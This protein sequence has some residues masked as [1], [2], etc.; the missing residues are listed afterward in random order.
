MQDII[1]GL[2]VEQRGAV[3]T[4]DGPL[5]ILAG[6]GSGKTKTLTHRIAN[7]IANHG[8]RP[9]QILA[10]TFTNKAAKEMR[11]RLGALL[12]MPAESRNFMPYMGT[13]HGVCVRILKIEAESIGLT[14][15]FVIYDEDDRQSLIK[16]SIKDLGLTGDDRLKPKMISGI[17][18]KEK[19][20][21]STAKTYES[22]AQYPLQKD[23]A[24]VFKRYERERQ[25]AGAL[26]FDDLLLETAHLFK[27]NKEIREKWQKK[28]RHIL[29][30]EYQ[31]T[32]AVQYQIVKLLVND[33]Q[34]I[35]VVGD[36]WQSIYSWRGADF[37]NILNFE[38]DFPGAKVVK[39][40]QNYRSTKPILDAAHKVI[41][42]NINRTDK[43]L[44]TA[45]IE[46]DPVNVMALNDEV[47][48]S[49]RVASMVVSRTNL[50]MRKFNDH[51]VLYRTNAQ[52][53]A[54]ERAFLQNG[55]PYKIIGGLKFYD[56][57]EIKD[58]MAYL[59][60]IYQPSDIVSFNRIVNVP[61]RGIGEVSLRKFINA[62]QSSGLS[63]VDALRR[64]DEF[65]DVT[66]KTRRSLVELGNLLD[67]STKDLESGTLPS[68][69]IGG[70]IKRVG[71]E[72]YVDD[73][74]PQGDDRKENLGVLVTEASA[75]A[76]LEDFLADAA[77][78]SSAD[79]S[80]D[81]NVVTLMTLHAAKGL[82][83][84]VVFLVGMEEGLLPHVRAIDFENEEDIEEERRLAYVGMTRAREELNLSYAMCRYTYGQKQYSM[85]SR[86]LEGIGEK[87]APKFGSKTESEKRFDD[88][89]DVS[90][91]YM[92]FDIGDSVKSSQFGTGEVVDIDG[93][94]VS[95]KFG[96]GKLRKLNVE[97][98]RLEKS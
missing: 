21:F 24:K 65:S 14:R 32:N 84:P 45:N 73:G 72:E 92:P 7:L 54:F 19:N 48:E 96:D 87:Y 93:M 3:E 83:F 22:M 20:D 80:A 5:L 1:A 51:A 33:D 91:D 81:G 13:F 68:V 57:K 82:E 67:V 26:D 18:S 6:A 2:N 47:E 74:T 60:L 50:G 59:K 31:D 8:I 95:V 55:V 76:S 39:L 46:G 58:I 70:L 40:E 85:P 34:N 97:Y 38:K 69:L 79:E 17:I 62:W 75:Y 64:S 36:D 41:T 78:M 9:E 28:F 30:D 10:V 43:K 86:F 35:C 44:W 29:I 23:I 88:D 61:K 89:S 15:N 37:T 27:G 66:P 42:K 71:Y 52:S 16:R 53:Y 63:L 25:K 12:D 4:L 11:T 77:L 94:A 56:R 49:M 98:A 90:Y